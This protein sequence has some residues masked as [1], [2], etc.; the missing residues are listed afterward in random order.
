[1][2]TEAFS[3]SLL[4]FSLGLVS[5]FLLNVTLTRLETSVFDE[6]NT[7]NQIGDKES[8]RNGSSL[9]CTGHNRSS[10]IC[11]FRFMCYD[12]AQ[13]EYLFLHGPETIIHGVPLN[14]FDPALLDLSSVDDHNTQY[15]N[16]V[17][18]PFQ[19]LES[20]PNITLVNDFSLI[21]HR[22]NPGNIMHVFHDDLL[23]M[24]HTMRQFSHSSDSVNLDI[25]LV[26]MEGWEEGSYVELYKLFTNRELILKRDLKK[27]NNLTCFQHGVIGI[28]KYTT[29]YQYGF[30]E[31]QGPLPYIALTGHYMQH[32]T[33]FIKRQLGL[34]SDSFKS[35]S[36]YV[37]L[38][39][40][41]HNRLIINE[42]DLSL[43]IARHLNKQVFRISMVTHSIK[44]QVQLI[45]NADALI[46]MHGSML[47]MGIFL[48][49]G[50][51][52]I[53]L[54]PY[55][56]NPNN[57][58]PYRTMAELPGM[59]ITYTSWRNKFEENTVTY[60]HETPESG[61]IDHLS[62]EEQQNIIN[63]KEVSAHLCCNNPYWLYRIY[64]D[65]IVDV[66]SFLSVLKATENWQNVLSRKREFAHE[67]RL[68]PGKVVNITCQIPLEKNEA[69][70]WL[71]WKPPRNLPYLDA[72]D[73]FYE[74]WI[75]EVGRDDYVAFKLNFTEYVFKDHLQSNTQY[76]VWIRCIVDETE[77]PFG[78]VVECMTQ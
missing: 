42:L 73:L 29:W 66:H 55:G 3:Q 75:Q 60:P 56:I 54:Y 6:I 49:P 4:Y 13:D 78:K 51:S 33:G 8:L 18:Y 68:Y 44:E 61:G 16:Y 77:G 58:T 21:F 15:F 34:E 50:A 74:V 1:M 63:T 9:W 43:A 76:F 11:K 30:K 59:S 67:H 36:P 7:P 48:P 14:R 10:R 40:R 26:L 39:S 12:P 28:S 19:A 22:F 70:L 37:V 5:S 53:E 71:S 25:R 17:D 31:P 2:R 45:S 23:P 52:L 32:F 38:C 72:Q 65:T 57:Y 27:K 46:G 20:F 62:E 41:D 47:I 24:Y 35:I 64:Q 69:G